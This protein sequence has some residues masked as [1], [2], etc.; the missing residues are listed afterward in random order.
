[1]DTVPFNYRLKV[2]EEPTLSFDFFIQLFET[3]VLEAQLAAQNEDSL[4]VQGTVEGYGSRRC[5]YSPPF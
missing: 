2:P 4:F 5:H 1:M 3:L